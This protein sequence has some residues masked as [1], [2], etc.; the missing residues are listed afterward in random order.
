MTT[1]MNTSR[2]GWQTTEFWMTML[3][4]VATLA[5][6]LTDVLPPQYAAI[7]SSVAQLGYS[8]ARG[9]SKFKANETGATLAQA[10]VASQA[11]SGS[12]NE[13]P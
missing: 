5:S 1:N 13:A 11:L 6:V 8:V 7:A 4:H 10:N 2:R 3:V 12:A 9:A